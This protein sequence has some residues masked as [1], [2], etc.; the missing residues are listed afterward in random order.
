M[1]E[2][3][4]QRIHVDENQSY[5]VLKVDRPY[6]VVPWHFH[7][8]IELMLVVEGEGTRFVG[9]S[10]DRFGPGDLVLVGAN[11]SHVWKNGPAHYQEPSA[12]RPSGVRAR[13]RVILFRDDC[14]GEPF[15]KTPEM[16]PVQALFQRA[17]RGIHFYGKTQQVVAEKIF[18]AHSQQ[19]TRRLLTFL[20]ILHDLTES[21]ENTLL[22]TLSY[23][24]SMDAGDMARLN[25]VLNFLMQSFR[26]PLR[27]EEVA[28]QAN[29]SPTAF[30]RYFKS[31]TNKTVVG[32]INELRVGYA[33]KLL[34]ET[35]AKVGDICFDCGFNNLSNFYEQFQ[36][37]TGRSPAQYRNEHLAR[38]MNSN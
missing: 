37:I 9:D 2:P 32:F 25:M 12:A 24:Q 38:Q 10:I 21:Q 36:A 34:I 8:E 20:D 1:H 28:A 23:T 27:L 22:S 18:N 19:G 6:F 5:N 3:L 15:F 4:F 7:P 16:Q 35:S 33:H 17:Q 31:R 11:L 30:C 13:A 26:N 14:F 29:M